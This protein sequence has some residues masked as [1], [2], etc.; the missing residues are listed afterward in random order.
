MIAQ[1]T[2]EVLRNIISEVIE[3]ETFGDDANFLEEL[4][5][6]SMMIIEILVRV[7]K[8]FKITIT[9][10]YIPKFTDINAMYS[11]VQELIEN[12]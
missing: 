8:T 10:D 3:E 9:E 12:K 5:V 6:D 1:D 11:A 2:K 7:E 4:G